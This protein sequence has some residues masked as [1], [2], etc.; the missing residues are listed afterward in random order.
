MTKG[1]Q[2]TKWTKDEDNIV[3]EAV[4]TAKK[5]GSTLKSAFEQAALRIDRTVPSITFRW[6]SK[7]KNIQIIEAP[8]PVKVIPVQN[9]QHNDVIDYIQQLKEE[10]EEFVDLK[11]NYENLLQDYKDL[12]D[13]FNS[14]SKIIS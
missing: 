4:H 6:N 14:I 7:L 8:Q 13:K 1:K 5:E 11:E 3:R 12:S 9:N 2:I 10:N